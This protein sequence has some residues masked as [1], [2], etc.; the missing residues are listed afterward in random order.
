MGK[1]VITGGPSAGK[2]TTIDC[3][4]ELGFETVS[5][6]ALRVIRQQAQLENAILP[7]TNPAKFQ[8]L[9]F[10]IQSEDERKCNGSNVFLDRCLVDIK[11]Y[12]NF[13]KAREPEGLGE[14]IKEAAYERVLFLESLPEE[15]WQK[16]MNGKPRKNSFEDG[17]RIAELIFK[18]FENAGFE[19]ARV[20]VMPVKERTEWILQSLGLK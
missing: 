7:W 8:E 18:E 16:T 6:S 10:A 9:A 4:K 19:I 14:A 5:E 2:T 3:L 13:F 11:A 15:Y 12:C 17:L 20:P 1:I